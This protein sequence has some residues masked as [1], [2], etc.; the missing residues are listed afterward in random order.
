MHWGRDGLHYLRRFAF[1]RRGRSWVPSPLA[2]EGQ[3]EGKSSGNES[4][5]QNEKCCKEMLTPLHILKERSG[6]GNPGP[7][8]VRIGYSYTRAFSCQPSTLQ[9]PRKYSTKAAQM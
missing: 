8:P 3:G 9:L 6:P 4:T 7:T 1:V 5:H 2:G